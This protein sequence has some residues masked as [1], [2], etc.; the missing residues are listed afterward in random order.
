MKDLNSEFNMSISTLN[1]VNSVLWSCDVHSTALDFYQWFRM[2]GALYREL[3]PLMDQ[4]M[5]DYYV[6]NLLNLAEKFRAMEIGQESAKR[7]YFSAREEN[8]LEIIEPAPAM[9]L[10]L[11]LQDIEVGLRCLALEGGL[12]LKMKDTQDTMD[13]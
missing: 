11:M 10:Y 1:R 13:F 2:L 9:E 8:N 12:Y 6:K 5:R 3:S 4:K 7:R